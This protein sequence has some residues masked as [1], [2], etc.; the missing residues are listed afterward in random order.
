M[1]TLI[2][3]PAYNEGE[4]LERVISDLRINYSQ[5]DYIVVNDGSK[6]NTEDVCRECHFN[7]V[8]HPV[9]LGLAG[10][11]Q[12][13]MRYAKYHGYDCAIQFDG[14]GQHNAEY[15]EPMKELMDQ[16][17]DIVIGSRFVTK[18]KPK[19]LRMLGNDMIQCAIKLTTGKNIS[20]PTS[21]MRLYN[22]TMINYLADAVDLGPEP[23]TIALMLRRGAKVGEVQVTMNERIAG[24][25]YLNFSK[26][27]FYMLRMFTSI[28][29]L[30]WIRRV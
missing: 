2:I 6:D 20:D 17:C 9:N 22:R 4:N 12:T 27:I 24:E 23:D 16:G 21:G 28:L 26:S 19:S 7:F 11:F 13:G 29:I 14:D 3:I 25:S 30:Q 15:I 18:K 5:Y 8:S 10:A 1:K